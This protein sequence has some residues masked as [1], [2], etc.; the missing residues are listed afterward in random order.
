MQSGASRPGR[1][2]Y[3]WPPRSLELGID[4][5]AVD[6]V[7]QVG[8]PRSIG[9][10]IQRVGRSGHS[11]GATPKGRLFPLTRDELLESMALLRGVRRGNLDRLA[12]PPWPVDVLAQQIVAECSARDW[13]ED[14]LFDLVRTAHPYREL[15]R[16]KYD[17]VVEVL[18]S[19]VAPRDGRRG[20]YLHRDAVN[21]KLRGRRGARLSALTSGGAIPDNADYD[22]IAEPDNVFVG[23]VNEDFAIE[24]M[25]GD[26][27]LLGNTPW[28]ILRVRD[29]QSTGG[30]RQGQEPDHP[31]LARRSAR[32]YDRAFR[33]GVRPSGRDLPPSR[34]RR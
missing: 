15:P 23:T 22:V 9:L 16:D 4:I 3:A 25:R 21:R 8:S 20:A 33:R 29:R 34:Y 10:L 31:V 30:G 26:V 27:F 11:L 6:L 2:R 12:V 18:S 32:P 28:Q 7:C 19:G 24:S 5:G 17:E 1:S 14:A 13:D